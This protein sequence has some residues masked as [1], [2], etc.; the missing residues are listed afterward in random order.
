MAR[1]TLTRREWIAV[2]CGFAV[3]SVITGIFTQNL[4]EAIGRG[5]HK[6][7]AAAVRT[8]ATAFEE[9]AFDRGGYPV[10]RERAIRDVVP[11]VEPTVDAWGGDLMVM[12]SGSSYVVWSLG[13]NGRPDRYPFGGGYVD[14]DVD[15]VI[16][17]GRFWQGP[18]GL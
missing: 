9:Y 1:R 11:G 14:P 3:V 16:H 6:K 8:A 2:S 7:S 15:V 4:L 13:K 12:S 5:Q 17:D 10:T 18:G